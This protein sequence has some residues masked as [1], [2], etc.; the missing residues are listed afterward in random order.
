MPAGEQACLARWHGGMLIPGGETD[1][2]LSRFQPYGFRAITT[3]R[4]G[5]TSSDLD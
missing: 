2:D 4:E 1:Q 3:H 5:V